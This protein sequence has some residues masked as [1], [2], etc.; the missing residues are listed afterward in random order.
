MENN[1][2]IIVVDAENDME[3]IWRALCGEMVGTIVCD[4]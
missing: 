2:P 3:N 4:Y 1:I